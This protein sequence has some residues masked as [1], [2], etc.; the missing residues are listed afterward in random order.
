MTEPAMRQRYVPI[1][2]N[3]T[4]TKNQTKAESGCSILRAIV[5][6]QINVALIRDSLH[7]AST[8]RAERNSLNTA[9]S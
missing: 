7:Q 2:I 5:A 6:I 1:I 3:M 9:F 8:V 4:A